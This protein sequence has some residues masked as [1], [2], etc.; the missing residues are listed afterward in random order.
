MNIGHINLGTDFD[1]TAA[2]FVL[3]VEALRDA[4]AEQHILVR[5]AALARR[6]KL[7]EGVTVGPVVHSPVMAY[8]LLPRVD[9]AHAHDLGA[10]HAGLLLA[11]TRS[12]PYVLTHRG[13]VAKS[14]SPLLQS[15]YRRAFR[16]LCQD[17]AELAMLLHWLPGLAIDVLPEI[18]RHESATRYLAVYQ[19]SQSMPIAGNNG[20]Q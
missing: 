7:V 20:I 18:E 19:N 11:L 16:V 3:L 5:D 14:V 9:V 6:L 13:R 17:D 10:G 15:I 12:I 2:R 8:C 1:S 4:G